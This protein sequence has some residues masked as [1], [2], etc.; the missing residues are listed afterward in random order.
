MTSMQHN[1]TSL[2]QQHSPYLLKLLQKH[3][4]VLP[5]LEKQGPEACWRG[6]MAMLAIP[7]TDFAS[8]EEL[9]KH[10]RLIKQRAALM[11]ALADISEVWQL[12]EVTL[13]LSELAEQATSR[14]LEFLL[15]NAAQKNEITLPDPAHPT[16]GSGIIIFAMGKLGAFEL[17]YSSDI[18]LIIFYEPGT[19]P[20]HGRQNEQHFMNKIAKGLTSLM[21][22]RTKDGYVFRTDLRLR[23]DPSAMPLAVRTDAAL[24]YYETVG[25]NWERAAMIKARTIA[26]DAQAGEKLLADLKPYVWRKNLDFASI[27]DIL[28]IKRQIGK[29]IGSYEQL[30]GHNIKLGKG[31][32]REIEF[33]VQLHQLIWG[34]RQ[35]ELRSR[36]T[37]KTLKILVELEHITEQQSE[38]LSQAYQFYRKLEHRLQMVEDQ[39]THILPED[40]T[41]FASIAHFMGFEQVGGFQAILQNHINNVHQLFAE[42]FDTEGLS[43]EGGNLVF[44]GTS[45]DP[46]TLHTLESMGFHNSEAVSQTIMDWHRGRRRCTRS[47]TSRQLLTELVPDIL[48][49]LANTVS[50]DDAFKNFDLFLK[51]LPVGIQLFSL[52]QSNPHMMQLMADVMGT[53][54]TLSQTLSRRPQL[55]ETALFSGFFATLPNKE[56]ILE[57]LN[58]ELE[59]IEYYDAAM[60]HLRQF[61]NE[62]HF[63]AGIQ[64]LRDF[65]N[66]EEVGFYLSSLADV[67]INKALELTVKEFSAQYGHLKDGRCA[68]IALGKLGSRELTF[69]SDVDLMF[70]YDFPDEDAVSD[71]KNA[72]SPSVY[73]N[74]LCQRIVGALTTIGTN[75]ALYDVDTRLRPAG[76]QGLLAVSRQALAQYFHHDAWTFE[77]M[78]LCKARPI[79]GDVSLQRSVSEE[80]HHIIC[81]DRD[82]EKLREDIVH[83]R[84][85]VEDAYGTDDIWSLKHCSGGLMDIDFTAQYI[86]LAC[87]YHHADVYRRRSLDILNAA[88]NN[89]VIMTQLGIRQDDLQ[90]LISSYHFLSQLQ[91]MLRLTSESS[92]ILNQP[93][94]GLAQLLV[95]YMQQTGYD[96]LKETLKT[97]EMSA[98]DA[99]M[100]IMQINQPIQ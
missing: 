40:P 33:F 7:F 93:P 75:G 54:P 70:V 66:S 79:A 71:G 12:E 89:P 37:L 3:P 41:A 62:K 72:R 47:K 76:E 10:L 51:E 17:N 78:A 80:I 61:K 58:R 84:K 5:E 1:P 81:Y 50:P 28:S 31:G 45:H 59:L 69:G 94:A 29:K 11:I 20:Y 26:G 8:E 96:E 24:Q 98:R 19:L 82:I 55:I 60:E 30:A 53:A 92:D 99:Y 48:R 23:P 6:I 25:Q 4:D 97:I 14:A 27:Q 57:E 67:L 52:I 42:S 87:A 91:H 39:Q 32:I 77:R 56:A 85:R 35:K 38:L 22:D 63:Q 18:D 68:I 21:Q 95:H 100:S 43:A 9:G 36:R 86:T 2:I 74:R 44:T 15:S 73:Y 13:A 65:T 90:T 64:L 49:A 34:G 88:A 83:M 46:D 16:V